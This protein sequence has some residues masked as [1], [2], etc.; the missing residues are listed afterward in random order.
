VGAR[1]RLGRDSPA[2]IWVGQTAGRLAGLAPGDTGG[3]DVHLDDLERSVAAA[4]H[5]PLP[6]AE[7]QRRGDLRS[8]RRLAGLAATVTVVAIAAALGLVLLLPGG[9]GTGPGPEPEEIRIDPGP[10]LERLAE[11]PA[12]FDLAAGLPEGGRTGPRVDL[13]AFGGRRVCDRRYALGGLTSPALGVRVETAGRQAGRLL[14][15]AKELD[16]SDA[17]LNARGIAQRY[18]GRFESC[19]EEL[20]DGATVRTTIEPSFL[21]DDG[22]TVIRES[23]VGGQRE[24]LQVVRVGSA[25]LVADSL[26]SGADAVPLATLRRAEQFAIAPVVERMCLWDEDGCTA[27]D[28]DTDGSREDS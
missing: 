1:R 4:P 8:R 14:V 28:E 16:L 20:V 26:V 27:T 18:V 17:D 23:D 22:W 12:D 9:S 10:V 21:G 25:V 19:P 3:A 15:V 24:I 5:R 11:V 13:D 7:I 6:L 2:E